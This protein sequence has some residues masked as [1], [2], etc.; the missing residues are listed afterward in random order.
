MEA[1]YVQDKIKTGDRPCDAKGY[2]KFMEIRVTGMQHGH[3]CR[4]QGFTNAWR[5]TS[6]ASTAVDLSPNT[7]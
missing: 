5:T 4:T 1:G 3:L 7:N 6:L 2:N